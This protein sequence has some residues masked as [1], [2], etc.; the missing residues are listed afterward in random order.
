MGVFPDVITPP[1]QAAPCTG[2]LT[3]FNA[4]SLYIAG[5]PI[6]KA[7]LIAYTDVFGPDSGRIKAD[8]DRL[9]KLGY[10]VAVVDLTG[11]DYAD[12]NDLSKVNDWVKKYPYDIIQKGVK[13]AITY[14]KTER[15]AQTLASYGY[16]WGAWIGAKQS[17]TEDVLKGHV[18]FHPSWEIETM[19]AG[20]L[21]V[22]QLAQ[23]VKAPQVLLAASNDGEFVRQG[24]SVEKILKSRADVGPLSNVVD[25]PDQIHGWVNRGNLSDPVVK[26]GVEKAWSI[27]LDFLKTVNPVEPP[28]LIGSF[29]ILSNGTRWT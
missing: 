10:S 28:S 9:G 1:L 26:A 8:A 20:G 12:P 7:G 13:D 27:A 29:P 16:C 19:H 3:T 4:T 14:L 11:G 22:D 23:G 24:G 21:T 6:S 2:S 17:T 15:G 25:F 18:S 5:P